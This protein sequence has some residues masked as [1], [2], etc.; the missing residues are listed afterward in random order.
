MQADGKIVTKGL[1]W[2]ETARRLA[3]RYRVCRRAP[4]FNLQ[5]VRRLS[6]TRRLHERWLLGLSSSGWQLHLG[7]NLQLHEISRNVPGFVLAA[8]TLAPIS[9]PVTT[10]ATRDTRS[11]ADFVPPAPL[12]RAISTPARKPSRIARGFAMARFVLQH[13][14]IAMRPARINPERVFCSFVRPVVR[15]SV[16]VERRFVSRPAAERAPVVEPRPAMQT[17]FMT[18]NFPPPRPPEI[19]VGQIADQVIRQIDHRISAWRERRGRS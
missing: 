12:P 16:R 7:L 19:N 1:R 5:W 13:L 11:R 15:E 6:R 2:R 18:A 8:Q 4:G 9:S 10:H 3:L 14:S 17:A